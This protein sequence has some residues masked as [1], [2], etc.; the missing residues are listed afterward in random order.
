M[1]MQQSSSPDLAADAMAL[2]RL[3]QAALRRSMICRTGL[4]GPKKT[5]AA[6][7]WIFGTRDQSGSCQRDHNKELR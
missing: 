5:Y 6:L 7:R 3:G 2:G 1:P 4:Q